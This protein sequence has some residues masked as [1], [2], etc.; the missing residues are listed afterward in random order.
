VKIPAV[1]PFLSETPGRTRW[2]GPPLGAHNEEVYGELLS[3]SKL[4]IVALEE[5]GII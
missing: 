2:V 3:L 5:Q 1:V 4:E